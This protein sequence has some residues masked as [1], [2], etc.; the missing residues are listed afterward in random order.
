ML[1]QAKKSFLQFALTVVIEV[2]K[3]L[4]QDVFLLFCKILYIVEFVYILQ[5]GEHF[6]GVSHIFVNIIKI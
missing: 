4:F 6:A 2:Y 1:P 5:I 3:E